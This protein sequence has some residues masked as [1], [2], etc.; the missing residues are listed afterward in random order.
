MQVASIVVQVVATKMVAQKDYYASMISDDTESYKDLQKMEKDVFKRKT[1]DLAAFCDDNDLKSD[2]SRQSMIVRILEHRKQHGNQVTQ[3][4]D[5]LL[6][7]FHAGHFNSHQ[8]FE[9]PRGGDV[10]Q[11]PSGGDLGDSYFALEEFPNGFRT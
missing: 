3:E 5:E 1:E 4:E 2:G 7:S 6:K 8:G 11:T 9:T 10:I